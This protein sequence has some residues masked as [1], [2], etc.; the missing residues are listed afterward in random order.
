MMHMHSP[1]EIA[2]NAMNRLDLPGFKAEYFEI[3]DGYTLQK[4]NTF[5][6]AD[7]IVA[8]LAVWVGEI[9]LIDNRI[10]KTPDQEVPK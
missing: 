10:L 5:D 1:E 4:I 9:R 8:C 2:Q 3:V 6:E 7:F